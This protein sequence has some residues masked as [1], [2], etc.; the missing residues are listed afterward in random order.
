[1]SRKLV[2]IALSGG[3]DSSVAAALLMESGY[4]LV[5]IAMQLWSDEAHTPD[6]GYPP[7]P[8]RQNVND[9]QEVCRTLGIPF[10]VIHL[11]T[12]FKQHVIDYFCREYARGRTPNPC[13][14][15]NQ[16]IK[17]G[18]L[19]DHALSLGVDYLATG[20]YARIRYYNGA[21]HLL[22]SVDLEKDQS[23]ML[24]T[25]GQEKLS[26]L[27]FPLGDHIKADIRELAKQKGLPTAGK[28]SSQDICFITSDYGSFLNRYLS[29][30]PGEIVNS[31][32]EVLG[33]HRGTAFYTIG[34]RH[35]L[36]LAT[37]EP[38]YVT[39]IEADTNRIVV[40][41]K[42]EL[43]C[44]GLIAAQINWV[45]G[46]IPTQPLAVNAKIRYRAPLI[47]AIIHAERENVEVRFREPQ[48]AVTPGQAVVFYQ[49]SEVLG[50]GIIENPK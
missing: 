21:Y 8:S 10:H 7:C 46:K 12:Q 42:E 2:A 1:M 11:K 37:P 13:I 3:V 45:S 16:H 23:Y 35:G 40:G 5:G 47:P 26:R 32:G 6:N 39:K 48:P 18:F 50:G 9:A 14:A 19:L 27:L 44:H 4:E 29:P 43:L 15:C 20:H 25:L 17:F 30:A 33:K 31:R 28:R 34:Q 36:G 22:Q 24:Y 49:G 38:L 41:T